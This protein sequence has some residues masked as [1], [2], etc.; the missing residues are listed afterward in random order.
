MTWWARLLEVSPSATLVLSNDVRDGAWPKWEYRGVSYEISGKK[1]GII[2]LGNIGRKV[3]QRLQGWECDLAFNDVVDIPAELQ[4]E[5]RLT[6]MN[7][8]DLLSWADILTL[9]VYLDEGTRRLIG[10]RELALMRPSSILINASRG[11]VIDEPALIAALQEGRLFGA[12]LDVLEQE[13][14]DPRNPLLAMEN[15]I[16]TSHIGA[17]T[18]DAVERTIVWAMENCARVERGERPRFIQ[19]GV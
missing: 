13:P 17:G 19:N 15:V 9:H 14:P 7:K 1:V 11:S 18:W 8:D 4:R 2:G 6:H 5:L 16:V 10:A 3:A 12:G